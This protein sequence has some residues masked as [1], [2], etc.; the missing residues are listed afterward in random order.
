M[1]AQN[2][3]LDI[4]RKASKG[5]YAVIAQSC[6]DAQS[7]LALIRAAEE[8]KSPAIAQLFPITMKQVSSR[9]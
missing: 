5:G 3:T 8:A 2:L 6:Y 1:T 7:V 4:L 9:V